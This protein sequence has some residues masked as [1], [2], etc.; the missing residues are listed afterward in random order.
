VW[1]V[2]LLSAQHAN[3]LTA[4]GVF[5][6]T[7]LTLWYVPV[8]K[9][10]DR[11][12]CLRLLIG[13]TCYILLGIILQ[14]VDDFLILPILWF[15]IFLCLFLFLKDSKMKIALVL[16]VS[17]FYLIIIHPRTGLVYPRANN[18]RQRNVP[19]AEKSLMSFH[20]LDHN[21]DTVNISADKPILIETWNETCKPCIKSI[22]E[23][24]DTLATRTD[25]DH[26]YLYQSRGEMKMNNQ[27][28]TTFKHIDDKEK[29]IID[30]NNALYNSLNLNA[31]P[32]FLIYNSKGEMKGHKVG[33]L[34]EKREELLS[35]IFDLL[36]SAKI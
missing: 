22:R 32:Y 25:F 15:Y 16:S 14:K 13:P 28:I 23:M 4:L 9:M 10:R 31:Y 11:M 29:I 18:D 3:N 20:F 24:Q 19:V 26:Y 27:V 12:S 30:I 35:E 33:Y 8:L 2:G 5:I 6:F 7:L 17:L 21:L 36:D 34:S 1:G